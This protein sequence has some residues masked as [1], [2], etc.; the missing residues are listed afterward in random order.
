MTVNLTVPSIMCDGCAQTV[1]KAIQS[2][3]AQAQV[4]IDLARKQVSIETTASLT[5]L[6]TA[7]GE[8]GH[9]VS[10]T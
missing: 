5:D 1:T 7:I 9:E 10:P 2:V 3:D 8:A 6:T 4:S